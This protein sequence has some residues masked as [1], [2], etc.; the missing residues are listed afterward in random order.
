[1]ELPSSQENAQFRRLLVRLSQLPLEVSLP[2]L[3]DLDPYQLLEICREASKG[4]RSKIP[5]KL[6]YYCDD[7]NFWQD[8]LIKQG[9]LLPEGFAEV[10]N[11]LRKK[12]E[13]E[14][15]VIKSLFFGDTGMRGQIETRMVM[16]WNDAQKKG[17][18]LEYLS[19]MVVDLDYLI[20]QIKVHHNHRS[21]IPYVFDLDFEI[22]RQAA[23]PESDLNE[24]LYNWQ[25]FTYAELIQLLIDND[26]K[27]K[28]NQSPKWIVYSR[29]DYPTK[30]LAEQD[31]ALIT[32]LLKEGDL[33]KLSLIQYNTQ[34]RYP[35][36]YDVHFFYFDGTQLRPISGSNESLFLPAEA[37][38][39]LISQKVQTRD[40]L[41]RLYPLSIN[42]TDD[43]GK[44]IILGSRRDRPQKVQGHTFYA[45][46]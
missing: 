2:V 38:P 36:F 6:G 11:I 3:M 39:F 18:S 46:Q 37:L 10:I 30:E 7:A 34:S 22:S 25:E 33:I 1:M 35:S 19:R 21:K 42:L 13:S 43:D 40:D 16:I 28:H 8:Y 15:S 5:V 20:T 41:R 44:E 45:K 27:I 23:E 31:A 29:P 26:A 12:G 9:F 32:D 4:V 14:A 17:K 24:S